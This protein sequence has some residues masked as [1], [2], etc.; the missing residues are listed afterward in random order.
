M[1]TKL[2]LPIVVAIAAMCAA[3]AFTLTACA[4]PEKLAKKLAEKDSTYTATMTMTHSETNTSY[5]Q[6]FRVS[7][8]QFYAKV[9]IGSEAQ[10]SSIIQ[11]GE[12]YY[13]IE[14]TDEELVKT[15]ISKELFDEANESTLEPIN[16][17]KTAF[18]DFNT[19][20]EKSGESYKLKADQKLA[21]LKISDPEMTELPDENIEYLDTIELKFEDDKITLTY[22]T[23]D[24]LVTLVFS[25][26]GTTKFEPFTDKVPTVA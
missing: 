15:E 1:K 13:K 7:G 23:E 26:I 19:Y 9:T 16:V 8:N 21:F 5:T 12:K 2:K 22:G 20:F 3:L 18:A 24:I 14:G 10:Y 25:E 11:E 4:T 6:D 17:F